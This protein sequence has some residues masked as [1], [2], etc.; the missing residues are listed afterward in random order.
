MKK[1]KYAPLTKEE[2]E[3]EKMV[4]N[5]EYGRAV[6]DPKM[7]AML[8][9]AA[10][11]STASRKESRVNIRMT[12]Q[13]LDLVRAEASREGIPYQTLMSSIIHKYLT[14]QLVDKRVLD[15]LKAVL[16]KTG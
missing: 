16:K 3:I 12:E 4:E 13:E 6:Y 15:D 11:N 5:G 14:R 7:K 2:L 10:R 9:D 8:E 1:R